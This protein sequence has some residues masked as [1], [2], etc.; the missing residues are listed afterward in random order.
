MN[1]Q[2]MPAL[3]QALVGVL[4]DQSVR[5]LMQ[6]LGNCQQPVA[7]R[8]ELNIQANNNVNY[9]PSYSGGAERGLVQPGRWSPSSVPS[10]Y[11]P[12]ASQFSSYNYNPSLNTYID[13]PQPPGIT[14]NGPTTNF[15]GGSQF[16]FPIDQT[17]SIQNVYPAPTVNVGGSASFTNIQGDN[18]VFRNAMFDSITVGGTTIYGSPITF[19]TGGGGGFGGI[20]TPGTPGA[21][22]R[23]GVPGQSGTPGQ[24]GAAGTP[25]APGVG[26]QGRVG[27]PGE[28]GR[29]GLPGPPGQPTS[30]PQDPVGGGGGVTVLPPLLPT[31]T[32]QYLDGVTVFHQPVRKKIEI[33]AELSSADFDTVEIPQSYDLKVDGATL[34]T[35]GLSVG[36]TKSDDYTIKQVTGATLGSPSTQSCGGT[37]TASGSTVNIPTYTGVTLSGAPSLSLPTPSQSSITYVSGVTFNADTCTLTVDTK[38]LDFSSQSYSLSGLSGTLQTGADIMVFNVESLTSTLT[39]ERYE[40]LELTFGDDINV[41]VPTSLNLTGNASI[42]LENTTLTPSEEKHKVFSGLTPPES[43]E[44]LVMTGATVTTTVSRKTAV[45][46]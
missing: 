45:T 40:D 46:F 44:E 3:A 32:I 7:S 22:G 37:V 18:V 42:S 14:I 1:T 15:Y 21:P 10:G 4:P 8:S 34:D 11:I 17:F 35:S 2:S 26:R 12:T 23:P 30:S 28:R 19:T 41:A 6:A 27:P 39:Y 20:G 9:N 38:T 25:G 5:A 16:A 29:D 33:P 24:P 13:I 43:I 31:R 36:I